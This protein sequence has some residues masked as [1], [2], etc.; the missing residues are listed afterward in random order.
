MAV[1]QTYDAKAASFQNKSHRR[2]NWRRVFL[3]MAMVVVFVTT[4]ML[5]LPAITMENDLVCGLEEHI[6]DNSCYTT[7]LVCALDNA[8]ESGHTHGEG[9]YVGQESLTCGLAEGAHVHGEDCR[10]VTR[11]LTCG[12]PAHE[13][14]SHGDG[15][16]EARE[17]LLC[18]LEETEGHRHD[19]ESC[20]GQVQDLICELA[21]VPAHS[22][23]T[24]CWGVE[25][26]LVCELPLCEDSHTDDCWAETEELTCGLT[27]EDV[28]TH[29]ESC[30]TVEDIL[31]CDH[32]GEAVQEVSTGETEAA[33]EPGSGAEAG[34][35]HFHGAD[36][37]HRELTCQLS[38][39][40]HED[41]CKGSP[42]EE[43]PLL[44]LPQGAEIP[45]GC[46]KEYTF[47]DEQGRF[48]A[49]VYAPADALPRGAELRVSLLAQDSPDYISA[50]QALTEDY[51]G[52]LA[53][54]IR[55]E[56]D[57]AEVEPAS[58]IYVC[59]NALGL[60][61]QDADPASITVEH[62]L[63]TQPAAVEV[64][65]GGEKGVEATEE[66][67]LTAAFG[68]DHLSIFTVR[69]NSLESDGLPPSQEGTDTLAHGLVFHLFDYD[70]QLVS[71]G[72]TQ[73]L[74]TV[75]GEDGWP[76]LAGEEGQSL[77][78]LFDPRARTEGRTAYPNANFLL[79]EREGR[80]FFDSA[81]TF[82]RLTD[83]PQDYTLADGGVIPSYSFTLYDQTEGGAFLPFNGPGQ[84]EE[85]LAFGMTMTAAVTIPEEDVPMAL[86]LGSGDD[87]W[88]FLDGKLALDLSGGNTAGVVSLSG[89][90]SV[91]TGDGSLTL[92]PGQVWTEAE[93]IQTL[94]PLLGL[95]EPWEA[96]STHSLS[97]FYLNRGA[98]QPTLRMNLNLPEG[99]EDPTI[100]LPDFTADLPLSLRLQGA[101]Q[102]V[103]TSE[104][105]I[106][107]FLMTQVDG[108]QGEEGMPGGSG[109][110]DET[111]LAVGSLGSQTGLFTLF[112]RGDTPDGT[113]YY[114]IY[115]DN[116]Q[117]REGVD[118][119]QSYYIAEVEVA[120]GSAD[121][122]SLTHYMDGEA[123]EADEVVFT[124]V[125]AA[126]G[127]LTLHNVVERSDGNPQKP[128][129][130]NEYALTFSTSVLDK[131][132]RTYYAPYTNENL[133]EGGLV[134]D[135]G[136]G[137]LA[138]NVD[139]VKGTAT[140]HVELHPGEFVTITLPAGA[141]VEIINLWTMAFDIKWT[142]DTA[143]GNEVAGD[144]VTA[145]PIGGDVELTCINTT[146]FQL[147]ETG[148][149]GTAPLL[150]LGML[151]TIGAGGILLILRRKGGAFP[152]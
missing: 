88:L 5:I 69:W 127:T 116:S 66:G 61:P 115:Q 90:T 50:A 126:E 14:H 47:T 13:G 23:G 16:Y 12:D 85:N 138:F 59:I 121:V 97:L 68:V 72:E 131:D 29:D 4:Y 133:T 63:E 57:G 37:Y 67:G 44:I 78:G 1:K 117:P 132:Y 112:F 58:P 146:G 148:G 109:G 141:E 136:D 80:Y 128:N 25:Q 81:E 113:Y 110:E 114:K 82:A 51:A 55:F 62:H 32:T 65:A 103:G 53:L 119:D 10:T 147:P 137:R 26:V 79:R 39:H 15:C 43:A 130:C 122:L 92:G 42:D 145:K 46:D 35:E 60:L 45:A 87:L 70:P 108:P 34:E 77:A 118:Y 120:G 125:A 106:F 124:N 7:Q 152:A 151:L 36:C 11:T 95:E 22:H 83:I 99:G 94:W 33:L 52:L 84:E 18:S 3:G 21:E 17:V 20:Y 27:E 8:S 24:D 75:L 48:Q 40:I 86:E 73:P 102:V 89:E 74:D 6:H 31:V 2:R 140:A 100:Y 19:E 41:A 91:T 142:G 96:G 101:E 107:R 56:L 9:C 76:V 149:M 64:V 105:W 54:D 98:G 104:A 49:A 93:G 38:E 123:R 143:T 139:R 111:V 71:G 150:A 135:G 134:H 30:V 144:T 28:H 129:A